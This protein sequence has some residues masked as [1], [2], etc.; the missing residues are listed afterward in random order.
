[1]IVA[2]EARRSIGHTDVE[3]TKTMLE[4]VKDT[5]DL[6]SEHVIDDGAYGTGPMPDLLVDCAIQWDIS[7]IGKCGRGAGNW[8]CAEFEGGEENDQ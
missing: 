4:P 1:M 6:R 7:V 8:I 5:V 3:S 2:V